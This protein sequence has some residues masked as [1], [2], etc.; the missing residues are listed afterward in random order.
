MVPLSKER[1]LKHSPLFS[2]FFPVLLRTGIHC[3]ST[4]LLNPQF[5]CLQIV[6]KYLPYFPWI[7]W[8]FSLFFLGLSYHSRS[9]QHSLFGQTIW[10]TGWVLISHYNLFQTLLLLSDGTIHGVIWRTGVEWKGLGFNLCVAPPHNHIVPDFGVTEI[11]EVFQSILEKTEETR[12][13]RRWVHFVDI[14][15]DPIIHDSFV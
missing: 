2:D 9:L 1:Y 4:S 12:G 15:T 14:W 3:L 8:Y 10:V 6:G 7:F 5:M 13:L 11:M